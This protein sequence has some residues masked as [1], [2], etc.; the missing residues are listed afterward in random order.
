MHL[1]LNQWNICLAAA[2]SAGCGYTI[3]SLQ[4]PL[5]RITQQLGGNDLYQD[6]LDGC[7]QLLENL[8]K[9]FSAKN[10]ES[11]FVDALLQTQQLIGELD[12]AAIAKIKSVHLKPVQ[13]L[14]QQKKSKTS[15]PD[16]QLDG[17]EVFF[18]VKTL[19]RV[20]P[21]NNHNQ[22]IQQATKAHQDIES[23]LRQGNKFATSILVD[24][25]YQSKLQEK[26]NIRGV[27]ETLSLKIKNNLK[28]DQF[29]R[30]E[31]YLVVNLLDLPIFSNGPEQI[32]PVFW[33]DHDGIYPSTGA[34][35]MTAFSKCG[36]LLF[37]PPEFAGKPGIEGSTDFF[38]VLQ[39]NPYV[40]GI[41]WLTHH[42]D[43]TVMPM[44]TIRTEDNELLRLSDE[45][46]WNQL[47]NIVGD[48]WND[49]V[50]TNGFNLMPIQKH[51]N[52]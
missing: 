9:R 13:T 28:P 31:T 7:T 49:D 43:E 27:I 30:G 19:A 15:E 8:S 5:Q 34:L 20:F 12:F 17:Y 25:P 52:F 51:K 39:K 24:Q 21:E 29:K 46:K 50:D 47:N 22:L 32:R 36:N 26:G 37:S 23:H 16:Y 44:L 42:L 33:S 11:G 6:R 35:W 14:Q 4:K 3:S 38:G 41:I 48:Y 18:E 40:K 1:L 45:A 10:F 2:H